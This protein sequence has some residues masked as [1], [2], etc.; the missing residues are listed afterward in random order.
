MKIHYTI[1]VKGKVQGVFYRASARQKAET[2]GI[3]GF[4]Q[5]LPDGTVLIE[6]EA[7]ESALKELVAWCRKGPPNA[8]VTDVTVTEKE[9]IGYLSFSVKR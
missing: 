3:T 9:N 7:E 8:E 6:A 1:V 2:L 4:A 5:N